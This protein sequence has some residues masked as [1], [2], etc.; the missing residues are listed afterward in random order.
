MSSAVP[1]ALVVTMPSLG[2]S[3]K[4]VEGSAVEPLIFFT[5]T[6]GELTIGDRW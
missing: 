4:T 6:R 2:H 3:M 1:S 5:E